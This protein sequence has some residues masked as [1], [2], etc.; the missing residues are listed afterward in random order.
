MALEMG[1]I[2]PHYCHLSSPS[3]VCA[4]EKKEKIIFL[5]GKKIGTKLL[6]YSLNVEM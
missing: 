6:E 3:L 4:E 1:G 5:L 2:L